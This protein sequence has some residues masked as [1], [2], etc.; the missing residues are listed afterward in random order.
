MDVSLIPLSFL[1]DRS[2]QIQLVLRVLGFRCTLVRILKVS[3][4]F[5]HLLYL[6]HNAINGRYTF[7]SR[8]QH[9]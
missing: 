4:T 3:S 5:C 2:A 8:N 7:K 6:H 1:K 9:P